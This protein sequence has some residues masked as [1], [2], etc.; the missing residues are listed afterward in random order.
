VSEPQVTIVIVAHSERGDL[1]RCLGSI[2]THAAMP[3][4]TVLVDNASTDDSVPWVRENR[5]EVEVVEL[6]RNL[7][8]AARQ[9]G[10]E[11]ARAE[12]IMFLDS[13]AELTEGALPTMVAALECNP[14]WGLI[15]PRLIDGD[16]NL[17]LSCR[18]FPPR[19]LPF[20]RRPPLSWFFDDSGFVGRHLMADIDHRSARPV[21]YV[22]GA[23]QLFRSSLARLA[24]PF[25]ERIFLGPDD[26][27]WCIRIRDAGGGVVYLPEATVIHRCR[28]R[29]R[30]S[31]LS[32]VALRHL[33][34]FAAFQWRY[35]KRRRDLIAQQEEMD[36]RY[37][38]PAAVP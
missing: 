7:G 30:R 27:E 25:P 28:R 4:Q 9:H 23:C 19:S 16:G 22:L 17:Q 13:D 37:Q 32:R 29:S 1:E 21:L 15:G 8:V 18:R 2:A 36:R 26:I 20:V 31:P 5:P 38:E 24:G 33:R 12:L 3:V 10:L 14:G 35:R 11:R 34:A 6:S